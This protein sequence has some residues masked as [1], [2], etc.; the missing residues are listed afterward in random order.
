MES[1]AL[2]AS[3]SH[4]APKA[5]GR[6]VRVRVEERLRQIDRLLTQEAAPPSVLQLLDE[7]KRSLLG[8]LGSPLHR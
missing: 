1:T 6:P 5:R 2:A 7:E 4:V 8:E 3:S